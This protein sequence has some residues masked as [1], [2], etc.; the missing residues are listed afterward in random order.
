[1]QI[2]AFINRQKTAQTPQ[3]P[4]AS[5]SQI[6]KY[7]TTFD[8]KRKMSIEI[9]DAEKIN[10][11]SSA[12]VRFPYNP[13]WVKIIKALPKEERIWNGETKEW[14]TTLSAIEYIK[15]Q[16]S[17]VDITIQEKTYDE[18]IPELFEASCKVPPLPHQREAIEFGINHPAF[19]NGDQQG[20]GKTY[21]SLMT[22]EIRDYWEPLKH[23]LIVCGVASLKQ[24]WVREVEKFTKHDCKILGERI[25]SRGGKTITTKTKIE[26]L[27]NIDEMPFYIITNIESLGNGSIVDVMSDLCASKEI[28]MV[29]VDE[30]HKCKNARSERGAG[31][32]RLNSKYKIALSGTP[33]VN[34]PMD[35]YIVLRWFG[36]EQR[37]QYVFSHYYQTYKEIRLK[38]RDKYGNIQKRTI[39][40]GFQ[41]MDEIKRKMGHFM[42]RRL[43]DEVLTLPNKIHVDEY[44]EMG[45]AQRKLYED[46]YQQTLEKADKIDVSPNPLTEFLR[47][48]EAVVCP[49]MVSSK[50]K[51]SVKLDRMKDIVKETIDNG[52]KIIVFSFYAQPIKEI[53]ERLAEFYPACIT[54]DTK[55]IEK[56]K[57]KFKTSTDVM[58][59]TIKVLGTGH[60]LTEANTVL[61][62]DLPWTNADLEQAED[63]AH[64]IGQNKPVTYINLICKDTIDERLN[65]IVSTKKD[66]A[67]MLVDNK[68]KLTPRFLLK[69]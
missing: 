65:E 34:N 9:R 44:L 50:I 27:E 54:A 7:K 33:I 31:L 35:S 16:I 40:T 3:T 26:D 20:L 41:H 10:A 59:G 39:V 37:N 61:F 62:L 48:R 55:D 30:C 69:R 4:S 42:I 29:I 15:A 32:L 47:L 63:R 56:E 57:E 6:Q 58:I 45:S 51:E 49:S 52:G 13:D 25:G 66:L 46:I 23:V 5:N 67:D 2:K 11:E 38:Q 14:E 24:N 1:M 53:K 36:V 43:K 8:D 64:R 18:K 68:K 21:E 22:A 28:G 19:L 17:S 60:T 12:F